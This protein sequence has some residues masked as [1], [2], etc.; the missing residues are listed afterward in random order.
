MLEGKWKDSVVWGGRVV[1][2]KGGSVAV[3]QACLQTVEDLCD[4]TAVHQVQS[5]Y[6]HIALTKTKTNY[7]TH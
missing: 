1:S 3:Y 7:V 6:H 2:V 5:R 4:V